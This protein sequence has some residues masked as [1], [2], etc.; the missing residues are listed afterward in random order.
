L[1]NPRKDA[2]MQTQ[3]SAIKSNAQF[4]NSA[5][6]GKKQ[7]NIVKTVSKGKKMKGELEFREHLRKSE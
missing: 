6:V 7:N 1:K 5:F 3:T 2:C 4:K